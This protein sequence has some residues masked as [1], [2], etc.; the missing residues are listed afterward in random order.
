MKKKM[1]FREMYEAAMI[2]IAFI[3]I[4][5]QADPAHP[6]ERSEEKKDVIINGSTLSASQVSELQALYGIER[7][8][9]EYS[10]DRKSSLDGLEVRSE[11]VN[12]NYELLITNYEEDTGM[13]NNQ[14]SIKKSVWQW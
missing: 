6:F 11:K 4:V 14:L 9:G 5:I 12:T 1:L 2:I 13:T 10:H 7:K 8:P 3:G